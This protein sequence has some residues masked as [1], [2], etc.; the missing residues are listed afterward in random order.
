[1]VRK[2]SVTLSREAEKRGKV[3]FSIWNEAKRSGKSIE[4]VVRDYQEFD[5]K[6]EQALSEYE[7]YVFAGDG[8]WERERPLPGEF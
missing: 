3:S 7:A 4:A 6:Y 5:R 8:N 2:S 1:V